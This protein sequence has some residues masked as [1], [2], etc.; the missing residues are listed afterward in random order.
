VAG[1]LVFQGAIM[2]TVNVAIITLQR[3]RAEAV[4][5][6]QS[7]RA[8]LDAA[9]T[10]ANHEVQR[11]AVIVSAL[12]DAPAVYDD[13]LRTLGAADELGVRA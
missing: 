9:I 10:R 13:A 11:H 1:L 2:A 12:E 3:G 6:L 5:Q 8:E 7:A 4:K